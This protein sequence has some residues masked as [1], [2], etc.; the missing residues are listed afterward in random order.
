MHLPQYNFQKQSLQSWN[1]ATGLET[2]QCIDVRYFAPSS[3]DF[4]KDKSV[5]FSEMKKL[6]LTEYLTC[7]HGLDV[8]LFILSGYCI[9]FWETCNIYGE[10]EHLTREE[11]VLQLCAKSSLCIYNSNHSGP[12]SSVMPVT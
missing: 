11:A 12:A 2:K 7:I 3:S 10:H 5:W 6:L 9:K 1:M 4:D 8:V